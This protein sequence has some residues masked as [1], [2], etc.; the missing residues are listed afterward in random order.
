MAPISL[1][2]SQYWDNKRFLNTRHKVS[3]CCFAATPLSYS[4]PSLLLIR[5]VTNHPH[6]K[7]KHLVMAHRPLIWLTV[8][9]YSSN[10]LNICWSESIWTRFLY[11]TNK[12]PSGAPDFT[13]GF[14]RGSCCPVICVSLF[15][16][17]VLSSGFEF[18]LFLLFDCLV[19]IF[20]TYSNS[21]C[22]ERVLVGKTG[23]CTIHFVD[24]YLVIVI[25]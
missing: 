11:N 6:C 1:H 22:V 14:H 23:N 9:S 18:W 16:V 3:P 4:I 7:T 19:S 21:Y 20:I 12:F 25:V 5:Y 17:I 8:L 24:I 10:L 15:H 2:S 13:S